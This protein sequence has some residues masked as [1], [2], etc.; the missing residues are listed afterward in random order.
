MITIC[1]WR[2]DLL[3]R[4]LNTIRFEIISNRLVTNALLRLTH[5]TYTET[6]IHTG[7]YKT[8]MTYVWRKRLWHMYEDD[9]YVKT[10]STT[11]IQCYIHGYCLKG[12]WQEKRISNKHLAE[13][14]RPSI[15]TANICKNFLILHLKNIQFKNC[16]P[17]DVK[18]CLP[19]APDG[20]LFHFRAGAVSKA[21]DHI[22]F[23]F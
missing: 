3:Y 11:I 19:V 14:L 23:G 7:T 22:I 8:F 17:F 10:T 20:N 12:H 4:I 9:I 15:W 18:T 13:C 21:T 16:R 2:T 6:Y 5:S 1:G